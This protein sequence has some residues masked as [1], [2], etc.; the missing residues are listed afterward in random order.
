MLQLF[1]DKNI[2]FEI[3]KIIILFSAEFGIYCWQSHR[4]LHRAPLKHELNL[5]VSH[6]SCSFKKGVLKKFANFTGKHLCWGLFL[7]E[8]QTFRLATL[9][10][11]DSNTCFHVEFTK[12]LRTPNLESANECF[13]NL[14]FHL[15][16]PF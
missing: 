1:Y 12:F 9:L 3:N 14:F 2:M 13:W 16:C 7:I 11:G 15:D 10:K 4:F 8:L 6:W 5:R